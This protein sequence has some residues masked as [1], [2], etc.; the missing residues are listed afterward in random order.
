M[1][2][3]EGGLRG[4]PLPSAV[5]LFQ[6]AS[7]NVPRKG[8]GWRSSWSDSYRRVMQRRLYGAL[9]GCSPGQ[10]DKTETRRAREIETGLAGGLIAAWSRQGT[11]DD[12][13]KMN[14]GSS[15]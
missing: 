2:V 13:A 14:C 10:R 4:L 5:D 11:L 15:G 8:D 9:V 1:G 3:G 6:F 12:D 7:S